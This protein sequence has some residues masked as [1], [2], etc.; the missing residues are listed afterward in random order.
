[1]EKF[2]A[3]KKWNYFEFRTL[4]KDIFWVAMFR[5]EGTLKTIY[6]PYFMQILMIR[7]GSL[8]G[9]DCRIP[10]SWIELLHN[11]FEE[12]LQQPL[13]QFH[14]D[15]IN[16]LEGSPFLVSLSDGEACLTHSGHLQ[17]QSVYLLLACSFSLISQ[18]GENANH[19]N[20]STLSS[21]FTTNPD[22]EHDR[23][24]MKKGFLELYK[25]IQRHLP[26]AISTN[27]DN[28]LEICMDFMSSFL[29]LYLR[30]VC[31]SI[32]LVCVL[33]YG[34]DARLAWSLSSKQF[35]IL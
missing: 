14:S 7:L 34:C 31:L 15:Q 19:C 12:F 22:S 2:K 4:L 13:T 35:W 9:L 18:R 33:V 20:C 26:T 5:V 30:E 16:C 3:K 17:R 1:L 10:F 24:C 8:T 28:F 27:H 23:F 11:Y 21:C 29:Q 32:Q 6:L 25:W